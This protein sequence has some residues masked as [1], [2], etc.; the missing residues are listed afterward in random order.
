MPIQGVTLTIAALAMLQTT[1]NLAAA[2]QEHEQYAAHM[3]GEAN[4]LVA[5]E[6]DLLEIELDSP[7]INIVGFEHNPR[8][9]GQEQIIQQAAA[10]LRQ[11]DRLFTL[12][13]AAGCV[14]EGVELHFPQSETPAAGDA[15]ED[16]PDEAHQDIEARYRYRCTAAARLK[17]IT[18]N[19]FDLFPATAE[20]EAQ[21]ISHGGQRQL[22][23]TKQRNTLEL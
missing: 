23:L 10:Q 20:V 3:H 2:E 22:E 18:L 21:V 12:P 13:A 4:L 15:G 9:P 8:D 17:Q 5:L 14:V 6:G 7:A 11:P 16:H 19:L 1:G